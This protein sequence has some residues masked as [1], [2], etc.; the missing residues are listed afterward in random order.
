MSHSR[1][2]LFA[3]LF[4]A[5]YLCMPSSY[6]AAAYD[7]VI[8]DAPSATTPVRPAVPTPAVQ[9]A[10]PTCWDSFTSGVRSCLQKTETAAHTLLPILQNDVLPILQIVAM[11]LNKDSEEA[12]QLNHV[13]SGITAGTNIANMAFDP[14]TG[15]LTLPTG[16]TIANALWYLWNE[17]SSTF[18]DDSTALGGVIIDRWMKD[19]GGDTKKYATISGRLVQLVLLLSQADDPK[20]PYTPAFDADTGI[21]KLVSTSTPAPLIEVPLFGRDT[22]VDTATFLKACFAEFVPAYQ[23]RTMAEEQ[24]KARIPGTFLPAEGTVLTTYNTLRA[25]NTLYKVIQAA[26]SMA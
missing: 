14:N 5:L 12:K 4:S 20:T 25:G 18:S 19:I 21:V 10:T 17:K 11:N 22:T 26:E 6:G 3:G 23:A 7:T 16:T 15:T 1:K 2:L 24:T 13:I 9:E 8:T